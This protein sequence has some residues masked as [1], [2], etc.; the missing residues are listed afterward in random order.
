MSCKIED[1]VEPRL[2]ARCVCVILY[3]ACHYYAKS[4]FSVPPLHPPLF[5]AFLAIEAERWTLAAKR[6]SA[7]DV[8]FVADN[9][10]EYYI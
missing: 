2:N 3:C 8:G 5:S 9:L 7:S 1:F 10:Y 4:R 6:L